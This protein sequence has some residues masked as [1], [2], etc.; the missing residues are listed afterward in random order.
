MADV[1]PLDLSMAPSSIGFQALLP[2][3][4]VSIFRWVLN[5]DSGVMFSSEGVTWVTPGKSF[6]LVY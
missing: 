1:S 2:F 3:F 6:C 5:F 4:R